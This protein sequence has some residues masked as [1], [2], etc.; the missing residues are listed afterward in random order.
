MA[1]SAELQKLSA[2]LSCCNYNGAQH[3]HLLIK[4]TDPLAVLKKVT[5]NAPSGDWFG[6][7]PDK[8]RGTARQMSP[9]LA[10]GNQHD[11][12]RACDCVVIINRGG[13]L[14]A[15]YFDLKS[16]NPKGYAGQFK[17][18][19]Q[20]VS[21]A[22]GLLEEFHGIKLF[23]ADERFIVLWGGKPALLNKTTTVPKIEKLGRTLP[24]KAHKRELSNGA[25]I[26]LKEFLA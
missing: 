15:L 19:R 24:D 16:G 3:T 7:D 26:Y 21:Y 18:T 17:S 5:L 10:V 9:L 1:L 8:G 20:F 22:L 13:E 25:T 12:H 14:T 23:L 11:H 2:S 6:F 4:E